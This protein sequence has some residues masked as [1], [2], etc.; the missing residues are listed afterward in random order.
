MP[1]PEASSCRKHYR[2]CAIAMPRVNL[3]VR[4]WYVVTLENSRV[5][6]A[7]RLGEQ[8]H[9]RLKY[10]L[11]LVASSSSVV[12]LHRLLALRWSGTC[13]PA[14]VTHWRPLSEGT[15]CD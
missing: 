7:G 3:C 4:G 6:Y 9:R 8:Y 13:S 14:E 5:L 10:F 15:S 11:T 12:N 2:H 1:N